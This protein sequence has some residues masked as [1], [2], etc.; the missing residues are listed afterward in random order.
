MYYCL[1]IVTEKEGYPAAVLIRA[2]DLPHADGPGKL[3][4]E[5]GLSK[6]QNGL[7]LTRSELYIEDRGDS[8]PQKDILKTPRIGVDYAGKD[9]K[10]PWRFILK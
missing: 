1:N 9:A 10:K 3:T 6:S 8:V 5:F 4:R 2:L 7:D